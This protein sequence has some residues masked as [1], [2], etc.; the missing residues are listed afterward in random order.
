MTMGIDLNVEKVEK[1]VRHNARRRY[2]C[3]LM[4]SIVYGIQG[5]AASRVLQEAR[6]L[7]YLY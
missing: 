1:C 7:T 4:L 3:C 5:A 6:T 2:G